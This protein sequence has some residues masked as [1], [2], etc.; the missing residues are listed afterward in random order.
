MC[1]YIGEL[2]PLNI[3][4]YLKGVPH[5]IISAHW[6]LLLRLLGVPA[7][8]VNKSNMDAKTDSDIHH[9]FE[10][11]LDVWLKQDES[12]SWQKIDDAVKYITEHGK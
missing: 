9:H 11:C 3:M 8:D 2:S 6:T 1:I 12:Q 10:D 5:F 4:E 7:N